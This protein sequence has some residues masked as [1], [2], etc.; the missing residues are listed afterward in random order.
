MEVL[1]DSV[2]KEQRLV[3]LSLTQ[4][5]GLQRY[6]DDQIDLIECGKPVDH[7]AGQGLSERDFASVLE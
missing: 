7:E 5:I 2:G 4:P 6:G 1:P 3:E